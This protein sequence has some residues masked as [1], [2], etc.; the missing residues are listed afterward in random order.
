MPKQERA[1]W[2]REGLFLQEIDEG[3]HAL[4]MGRVAPSQLAPAA[5]LERLGGW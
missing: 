1:G 3:A 4:F 2:D 5:P